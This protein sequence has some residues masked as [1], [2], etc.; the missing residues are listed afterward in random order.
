MFLGS[1]R[2]CCERSPALLQVL[3]ALALRGEGEEGCSIAALGCL[4]EC[5]SV[6]CVPRDLQPFLLQMGQHLLQL[7]ELVTKAES[8]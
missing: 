3:F 4:S 1:A 7:L 5:L 2:C 8:G 6:R